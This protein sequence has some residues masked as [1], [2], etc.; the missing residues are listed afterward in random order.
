MPV[1]SPARRAASLCICS[2]AGPGKPSSVAP[3]HDCAPCHFLP[4]GS[5]SATDPPSG[6]LNVPANSRQVGPRALLA[7]CCP[8]N[9]AQHRHCGL[10]KSSLRGYRALH[11]ATSIGI[12]AL[13]SLSFASHPLSDR[14]GYIPSVDSGL[15]AL[16]TAVVVQNIP[17]RF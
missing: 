15:V 6:Q 1:G 9:L 16:V 10:S 13:P 12:Q 2:S 3:W 17:L 5:P 14:H 7:A 11:P 4:D 8:D